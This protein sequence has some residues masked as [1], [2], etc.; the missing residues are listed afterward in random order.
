M[1]TSSDITAILVHRDT[2]K[3]IKYGRKINNLMNQS[4]NK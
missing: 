2:S 1:L 4:I 3:I